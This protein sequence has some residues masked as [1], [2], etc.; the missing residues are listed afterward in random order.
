MK[1]AGVWRTI[2]PCGYIVLP[3]YPIFPHSYPYMYVLFRYSRA[4]VTVYMVTNKTAV[5]FL[6]LSKKAPQKRIRESIRSPRQQFTGPAWRS[7]CVCFVA[8]PR[9]KVPTK[10]LMH[11]PQRAA[12]RCEVHREFHEC[13]ASEYP[14]RFRFWILR[15]VPHRGPSSLRLRGHFFEQLQGCC[16]TLW[17]A[18][19]TRARGWTVRQ[20]TGSIRRTAYLRACADKS[21]DGEINKCIKRYRGTL[22]DIMQ[23]S[24]VSQPTRREI[25]DVVVSVY[26]AMSRDEKPVG[27][28]LRQHLHIS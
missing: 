3:L 16:L 24:Y 11:E 2:W 1:I 19:S 4:E 26:F 13:L 27:S 14:K 5:F 12:R 7:V 9:K 21:S 6:R 28:G 17:T 22:V 10:K 25:G 18:A 20:L 8:A 15:F 23:K